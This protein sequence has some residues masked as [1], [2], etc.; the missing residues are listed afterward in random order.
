MDDQYQKLTHDEVQRRIREGIK[1]VLEQIME[2]E[3]SAQLQ[4]KHRERTE[5]RRGERNGHYTRSLTTA[6]GHIEQLRVP[7][8]REIPFLTEVFERYRRMTGSLEEAVL[9]MYL[10]GISTRKVEAVTGKLTGVKISKDAVSRI[11]QRLEESLQQWR[12]HRF[13]QAYPYLYLDATYLK[14]TWAGAVRNVALLVAIGVSEEGYR[15]VLGVEVAPGEQTAGYRT[16]L[17]GLLDR[18]LRGVQLVISD[19]HEAIKAAVQIELPQAA[20]QRCVVHFE[21]NILGQ[22]P[23]SQR[24]SVAADLKVIFQAARLETAEQLA[25]SF[26]ERYSEAYPKAVQTLER[27]LR[28]ALT[29]TAFPSS[30]HKYI[31][32]TNG[33]ER[34]FREVKRRT[35]VVGVFPSEGSACNLATVV[36]LRVSEDW[37][38]R[39]YL[40][41]EPLHALNAKPT[42]FAT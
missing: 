15:E 1:S 5:K 29:Y 39:R 20:W 7:R 40:N 13:E 33:L 16:Y 42:T 12:T 37:A 4:A 34:L 32:T 23:Q 26:A 30:H 36:L 6:S 24:G 18:G 22:V 9:E 25:T 10:Q 28:E 31:R 27:G 35:R 14:A 8:A 3:M 17:K 19:D 38:F 41:M 11:A 21:R 2:E